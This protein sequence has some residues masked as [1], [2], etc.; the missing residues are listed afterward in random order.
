VSLFH[1]RRHRWQH[2]FVLRGAIIEP[3]TPEGEATARL[4]KLNLDKRVVE[5][6]M[7]MAAGRYPG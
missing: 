5:R 1:P 6:Q 3:L 7:L 4:L 2:H